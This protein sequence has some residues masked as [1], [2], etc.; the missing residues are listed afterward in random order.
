MEG[1]NLCSAYF[2]FLSVTVCKLGERS[3]GRKQ[4]LPVVLQLL[5]IA[6]EKRGH[7]ALLSLPYETHICCGNGFVWRT[8]E[9]VGWGQRAGRAKQYLTTHTQT[10]AP[11]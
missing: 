1:S 6:P 5:P 8:V 11:L 4:A 10:S 2:P 3:T 9:R 7:G